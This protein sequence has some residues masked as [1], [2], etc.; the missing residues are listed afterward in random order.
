M[1]SSAAT[2]LV[3]V[4]LLPLAGAIATVVLGRRLGP[5]AH[6]PAVAGIAGA[7]AVAILLLLG[8]DRGTADGHGPSRPVEMTTTLWE[9]AGIDAASSGGTAQVTTAVTPDGA[10]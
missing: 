3:L 6:L 2:L 5:R 1:P 4:P 7:A 8:L 10:T 9:W